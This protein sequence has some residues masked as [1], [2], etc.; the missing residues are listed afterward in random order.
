MTGKI[1]RIHPRGFCFVR[2]TGETAHGDHFLHAKNLLG[3]IQFA[4]LQIGDTIE[5]DSAMGTK[6]LVCENASLAGNHA[7]H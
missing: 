6:G 4:D 5:F 2:P 7:E 3:G 1:Q